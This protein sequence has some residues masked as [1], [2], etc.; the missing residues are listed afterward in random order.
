[1]SNNSDNNYYDLFGDSSEPS[2]L[3]A[4]TSTSGSSSIN[5]ITS[6]VATQATNNVDI[7][8]IGFWDSITDERVNEYYFLRGGPTIILTIVGIYLYFVLYLGPRLMAKHESFKLNKL[9]LIYNLSMASAN[10]WIFIQG[11][12]VS[13]YGLDTLGCQKFGG[14]IKQSPK[15]GI[16]LGYL[17]FL[18]KLIELLDTVFFI[19]RKKN[20]QITF[21]HVFHHS[22]V[23]VFCWVALKLAPGV[24][25]GFFPLIN[26]C[27]HVIMYF[28]YGLSTFGSWIQPYL[29]WKKYLTRL[30]MIQ[31]V[32]V[33]FNCIVT[34][35]S[36]DCKF[37][38]LFSYLQGGVA[39]TF[40]I[41]FSIY[42]RNAYHEK[43]KNSL[44]KTLRDDRLLSNL[45]DKSCE[46]K[47][48]LKST[49]LKQQLKGKIY[50]NI[51]NNNIHDKTY[52]QDNGQQ[53]NDILINDSV[54]KQ[55]KATK[56]I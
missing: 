5:L 50:N 39:T 16:Y 34:S 31:F 38:I 37:P 49:N 22:F 55:R 54:T 44:Q 23:P 4:T 21:L 43:K 13:N 2:S 41:L 14:D 10:L 12:W 19:L 28:Y 25:N 20:S 27:I 30:Q 53:N 45:K 36:K 32:L 29:W 1:M 17:F 40:L 48:S 47:D 52:K 15:R 46:M 7:N 42:Y 51:D 11:L 6:K 56:V 24:A 26:S 3:V 18:T 33:M 35:L 9:L 8:N